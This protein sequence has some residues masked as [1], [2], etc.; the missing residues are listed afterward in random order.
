LQERGV[1]LDR[2]GAGGR[3]ILTAAAAG[4][5]H[6][7]TDGSFLETQLMQASPAQDPNGPA[8]DPNGPAQSPD[9]AGH[10]VVPSMFPEGSLAG[11]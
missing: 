6:F 4:M 11:S 5:N 7:K 3:E 10:P 2:R 1:S 9:S 8:Q